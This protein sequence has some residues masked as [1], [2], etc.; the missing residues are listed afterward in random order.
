MQ[1][2]NKSPIR[3][4]LVCDAPLMTWGLE[5]LIAT[6]H[7]ELLLQGS[8]TTLVEACSMQRAQPADVILF[9]LDQEHG[10]V[11][12]SELVVDR[13]TKLLVVN[14]S[15]SP[16]AVDA[17]VLAGAHGSI[18]K[19]DSIDV[20]FKA[21]EK[22]HHGEFWVDRTATVRLLM[23][24]GRSK[25]AQDPERDKIARLTRKERLTI[26]EITRDASA[27]TGEIAERLCISENTLRNHL[28]SIYAKL[29]VPNRI[30]LLD[31]AN[32]HLTG[33]DLGV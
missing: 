33:R 1:A 19:H 27:S 32:R 31:Y 17:A 8:A 26:A 11:G 18:G 13:H 28:T 12:M 23:T 22:V 25:A 7:P 10:F 9:D 15:N 30:S 5:R 2:G 16:E 21:I 6:K 29:N 14:S 24:L 4:L 20:L 3:I